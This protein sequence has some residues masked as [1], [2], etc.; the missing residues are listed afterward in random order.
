M[1]KKEQ[2]TLVLL[3][4]V[5]MCTCSLTGITVSNHGVMFTS[6]DLSLSLSLLPPLSLS[7]SSIFAVL[8]RRHR[9]LERWVC[10]KN[11]LKKGGVGIWIFHPLCNFI[12]IFSTLVLFTLFDFSCISLCTQTTFS[13]KPS[14]VL[15]PFPD[16]NSLHLSDG[17]PVDKVE[18]KEKTDKKVVLCNL[19]PC[20]LSFIDLVLCP[21]CS[22]RRS[23]WCIEPTVREYWT[24]SSGPIFQ[25]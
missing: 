22:W 16:V 20:W 13:E 19:L 8:Q 6:S 25:K 1:L 21:P 2:N 10:E 15:P 18:M 4:F 11:L 17:I 14:A 5:S 23:W 9:K 24:V 7:L 3:C 12:Y